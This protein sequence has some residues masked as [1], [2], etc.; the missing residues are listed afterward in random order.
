MLPLCIASVEGT[1]QVARVCA[2]AAV[3]VACGP[4]PCN[5]VFHHHFVLA[6]EGDREPRQG[7]V[8]VGTAWR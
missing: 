8:G 4:L 7:L 5:H 2:T 1:V 3:D 6:E